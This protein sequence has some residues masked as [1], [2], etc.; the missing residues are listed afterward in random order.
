[1]PKKTGSMEVL[2]TVFDQAALDYDAVRPGYPQELIEDVISIS[3][4]PRGGRILEVGCGTGQAT[5][6]FA[7]RGYSMLCLDIGRKLAAIAAQK[8]CQYPQVKIQI[9]SFEDW[10]EEGNTFDLVMSA[11]AFHWISPEVGYPKAAKALKSSGYIALFTNYHPTPH[12]GFFESVQKV[13][14]K[15]VPEWGNPND[16][17]LL[18]ERITSKEAYINGTGLFENT[19]IKTYAWTRDYRTEEYIKL[20]NTYSDHLSL[21]EN[22]RSLLY[23]EIAEFIEKEFE[24]TV[25]RPYLSVLYIARKKTGS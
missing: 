13:Y 4:I 9:I 15:I 5:L 12:T 24:G 23:G 8:C 17:P 18:E 11:T 21:E 19:Q 16:A 14:Q 20:L 25:T 22:R 1:M 3:S 2:R 7:K 6:P 10:P